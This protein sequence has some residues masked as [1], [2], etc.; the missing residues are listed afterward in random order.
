MKIFYQKKLKDLSRDLRNNS[1]LAEALLWE[2]LKKRQMYGLQFMRQKPIDHFIV[3]FYCSAIQLAIEVD[4]SSHNAIEEEDRERQE[5][6]EMLGIH[7]LRFKDREIKNN[8]NIVLEHISN[9]IQEL[10]S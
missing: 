9:T 2:K 6:L 3:D 4:G 7:F 10:R 8:I 5:R 1:T